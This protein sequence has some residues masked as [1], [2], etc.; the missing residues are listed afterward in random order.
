MFT[1][2]TTVTR[3]YQSES[4][5]EKSCRNFNINIS[6]YN[7]E[8]MNLLSETFIRICEQTNQYVLYESGSGKFINLNYCY[9]DL[10]PRTKTHNSGSRISNKRL[11][12]NYIICKLFQGLSDNPI[13]CYEVG[14]F[15]VY[16]KKRK[17]VSVIK[18]VYPSNLEI[19]KLIN[20]FSITYNEEKIRLYRLFLDRFLYRHSENDDF[21]ESIHTYRGIKNT[22]ISSSTINFPLTFEGH[23]IENYEN[24][25][26]SYIHKYD[27]TQYFHVYISTSE[28]FLAIDIFYD[29]PWTDISIEYRKL[30]NIIIS[31][32]EPYIYEEY[33]GR[34][35]H[36][37]GAIQ[38]ALSGNVDCNSD[39]E[40]FTYIFSIVERIIKTSTYS[41]TYYKF[42]KPE[43]INE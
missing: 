32:I 33:I 22:N 20:I 11:M 17:N 14:S 30:F 12:Y 35:K 6:I 40:R 28:L 37:T 24:Y 41:I 9:I 36:K 31:S 2:T 19:E 21:S 10:F 8:N 18:L 27:K 3:I 29:F 15:T 7:Y 26:I 39:I 1:I 34:D 42:S 16:R 4:D 43:L 23:L 5:I 38:Y 25:D 13:T